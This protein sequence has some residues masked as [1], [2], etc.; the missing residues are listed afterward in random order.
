MKKPIAG[1]APEYFFKY[2]NL[3]E[4]DSIREIIKNHSEELNHFFNSIPEEKASFAYADGKWDVKQVLQHIIDT[5]RVFV[6]RALCFARLQVAPLPGMDENAFAENAKLDDKSLEQLKA[7]FSVLRKSTDLFLLS[8]TEND[9]AK[10]GKASDYEISVNALS[11][12]I[13]G[14]MIHHKNILEERYL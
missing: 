13:L 2:I 14:H 8:L 1:E 5:E 6:Y 7:E 11:Y 12:V 4:G 3:T 9:L 10:K